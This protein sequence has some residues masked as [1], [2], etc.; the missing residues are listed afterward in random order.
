VSTSKPLKTPELMQFG[1]SYISSYLKKHGHNTKLIVLSRI[2]GKKNEKI[3]DEYINAF[4]P[5]VIAFTAVSTEYDFIT[6]TAKYIRKRYPDIYL[7]IGGPHVSLNPEGVLENFDALC[8]GEGER[9]TLEL[10]S[11]LEKKI[12]P[13][14]IHNLWIRNG[15][16]IEKNPTRPFLQN[17]DILPFPDREMWNE[18]IDEECGARYSVLLGRGCPFECTY[19][20]NHALKKLASGTYTR[21]RSPANIMDE[22]K[23]IVEKYPDK[24][25]LYLEVESIGINKK[26]TLDLCDKLKQFNKT[27]KQPI[28]FGANIRIMPNT[29]FR[30][31]FYA[32]KKSNFRF[33]NIGL[34]SGSEKVRREILNRNYSNEDI[35][36]AVKLAKDQGLQVSFLN[37]IGLPGE[38]ID[39]FK[40]T[41]E[42]NQKCLPDWVG[43]SIFYPYPGTRIYSY[44][45][46]QGLIKKS[47]ATDMERKKA[48]LNL[49]GFS[50][51]QIEE[52]YIW[53]EY[54]VFKGHKPL[55]KLLLK[56]LLLKIRSKS[57]FFIYI[58][59][60]KIPC[61]L[62]KML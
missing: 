18:W 39:D 44:C 12:I 38:T 48:V 49:P 57:H 27:L 7:L 20:C 21:F 28:S 37:M 9:P 2:S 41:I 14:G 33:I 8:I 17:L 59:Y 22:I 13:S 35:I 30:S 50:K 26:W 32:F 31:I 23:E 58:R 40:E 15:S 42:M 52:E 11:Q 43:N 51:K 62:R 19:C 24:K 5:N 1:V 60:L 61:L 55:H 6:V 53:F 3:I 45:K 54:H 47:L 10:V 29:D 46:E 25:E 34:E 4:K 16:E 56:T 36:N